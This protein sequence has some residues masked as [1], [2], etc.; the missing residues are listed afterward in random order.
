MRPGTTSPIW[1]A[2]RG[3]GIFSSTDQ[4]ATFATNLWGPAHAGAPDAWTYLEVEFA[5]ATNGTTLYA[6]AHSTDGA[7][8][9]AGLWKSTDGGATWNNVPSA[10]GDH[11]YPHWREPD[12][13]QCGYAQSI[14]VDPT[15]AA[16]VYMGF[17]D[18]WS[19]TDGGGTW[20]NLSA[21]R[22]RPKTHVDQ[23]AIVFSPATH[24]T[25]NQPVGLWVGMDGGVWSSANN[26][27]TWVN[28]NATIA[29]DLLYG[30][31][32]GYGPDGNSYTYGGMQDN[33]TAVGSP[34]TAGNLWNEYCGG[35]GGPVA[36]DYLNPSISLDSRDC[37]TTD[38]GATLEPHVSIE[39][40]NRYGTS[41][42]FDPN[43]TANVYDARDCSGA[44]VIMKSTD[45]ASTFSTTEWFRL[46]AAHQGVT[47]MAITRAANPVMWVGF[48]D[49]WIVELSD[50]GGTPVESH[51]T[52]PVT[53]SQPA[54][55]AVDPANS[56]RVAVV[57]TGYSDQHYPNDSEHV[58]LS[59]DGGVSFHAVGGTSSAAESVP[60]LPVYA[61]VFD[62]STTP[63]SLIIAT[64]GGVLRSQDADTTKTWQVLGVGLP[65]VQVTSLAIDTTVDPPLLK[66]GTYG[67][68]AWQIYTVDPVPGP[69]RH[70]LQRSGRLALGFNYDGRQQLFAVGANGT[71]T[72]KYQ[73]H[74]GG[75]STYESLGGSLRTS[76]AQPLGVGSNADRRLEIYAVGLDKHMYTKYQ[77]G[78]DAAWTD[79]IQIGGA[80]PG[81]DYSVPTI[82]Y[83]ADG[84]QQ[85]YAIGSDARLWTTTQTTANSSTWTAWTSL[86]GAWPATDVPAVGVNA[87]GRQ[88]LYLVGTDRQLYTKTQTSVNGAFATTW[89]SFGGN[90]PAN[91]AIGINTDGRQQLYLVG[92]D[93]VLYT[94]AQN[95][96]NNA[97]AATWTSLGC[98]FRQRGVPGLGVNADGRQQLLVV[99]TNGALYTTAQTTKSGSFAASWTYLGGYVP[100]D[101]VVGMD[102][103]RQNVFAVGT[104]HAVFVDTQI[105]ANSG[106]FGGFQSLGGVLP[107]STPDAPTLT[108]IRAGNGWVSVAWNPPAASGDTPITSYVVTS[109]LGGQSVAVPAGSARAVL[110]VPNG[111]TQTVSVRAVNDSG[112]GEPSNSS[113]AFTPAASTINVTTTYN[114]G[115]NTRLQKN[116]TYFAQ[117][118]VNAQRTSVGIVAYIVGLIGGPPAP[119]APPVSTGPNS[120]TTPWSAADQAALVSAMTKYGLAPSEAQYFCVQLVGYLLALGG[121]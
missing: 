58:W 74:G 10:S 116:A 112:A 85:L 79:W 38:G 24:R 30:I 102:A 26:G 67:R 13:C 21:P 57:Y 62:T 78:P 15:N 36:V 17:A 51:W 115:D 66:A 70:L 27:A 121:N 95:V 73:L 69:W 114:A 105:A 99:G 88:E 86:G 45:H 76:P 93:G 16:H 113:S 96:A 56:S 89:T 117:T 55:L 65:H 8:P 53:F 18:I 108:G 22:P 4:G 1:A 11:H 33:G 97:W 6:D 120:T 107:V 81:A 44:S 80:W 87:D 20:T 40:N 23:H 37:R 43:Q 41:P 77:T 68:S 52:R 64:D 3:R 84:R 71:V 63:S 91:P 2:A 46:S 48:N 118:A 98:C 75:W 90:W 119:I 19:S 54:H 25:A 94:K 47:S 101:V 29:S 9:F 49:G 61:A 42:V 103:A 110:G 83:N 50:L 14:G 34:A 35:D 106:S 28:H 7:N 111:V 32:T 60:N 39:C 100:D 31:G 92:T 104:N 12:G 72:T 82:G 5:A 109:N 59:N